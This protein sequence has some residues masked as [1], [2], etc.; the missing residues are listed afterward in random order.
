MEPR[1]RLVLPGLSLAVV[2]ATIA[3]IATIVGWRFELI[4]G[5][6]TGVIMGVAIATIIKPGKATLPGIAMASRTVLQLSIVLLGAQLSLHQ[7]LTAGLDSLPVMIG[8]LCACLIGAYWIGRV[9]GIISNLRTLIG[10]G[11]GVCG[12][13]AIAAVT[14]VIGAAEIEVTYALSTIFLFNIAAV[15]TFPLIGHLLGMSQHSFGLFAGTAVN[16]MSSVVATSTAYGHGALDYAIVV[17]LTRT[18]MIIPICLG[19][20][21]LATRSL[22]TD[23]KAHCATSIPRRIV[24]L[25]PW[26]LIGFMVL[27]AINSVGLIPMSSQHAIRFV[28]TFLITVA[29]SAIGLNTDI[30]ALCRIGPQPLVLGASLWLVVSATSLG[31]QFVTAAAR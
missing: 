5:P 12:A 29:L 10:V 20:S 19:L 8:T 6:V 26:F 17:K 18:L 9:L 21:A 13:S 7:V 30:R 15:L 11:T 16:D 23:T 3:T 1:L 22:G 28:A 4:G 14:T 2:I 31:L 24:G 25:V 27:A